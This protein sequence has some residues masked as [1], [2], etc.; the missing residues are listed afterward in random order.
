MSHF[1][2]TCKT[3]ANYPQDI[4]PYTTG[5]TIVEVISSV[6]ATSKILCKWHEDNYIKTNSN[7]IQPLLSSESDVDATANI[8]EDI[9]S[10]IKL[11][12][13]LGVTIDYKVTFDE[14]MSTIL[15][16]VI[17]LVKNL[18]LWLVFPFL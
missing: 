14:L 8:N 6:E 16:F 15:E 4:A 12:K 18:V 1:I 5:I 17:R 2:D 7:K 3:S 10:N 9:I 11:E 13:L